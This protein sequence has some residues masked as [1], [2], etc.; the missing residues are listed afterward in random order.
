[1]IYRVKACFRAD[2]AP[3]LYRLL[4]DGT[5]ASQKPGG[6]EI[7]E[8]M[9]RAKV[10]APGLVEWT[11]QCFCTEPLAHERETVYDRFFDWMHIHP[12]HHP[13]KIAGA[14]FM[15]YLADQASCA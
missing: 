5:I 11:E 1:M 10:T 6:R 9:R 14:P 3:E 8:S 2:T 7:V 13:V 4:T 15:D 12:I